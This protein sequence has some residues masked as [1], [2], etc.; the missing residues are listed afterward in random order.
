MEEGPRITK[1]QELQLVECRVLIRWVGGRICPPPRSVWQ[2]RYMCQQCRYSRWTSTFLWKRHLAQSRRH[3]SYRLNRW[4]RQSGILPYP[5]TFY[6]SS[7]KFQ[8][9]IWH[10]NVISSVGRAPC[11]HQKSLYHILYV[12]PGLCTMGPGITWAYFSFD[13]LILRLWG[14]LRLHTINFSTDNCKCNA[15]T[16]YWEGNVLLSKAIYVLQCLNKILK[17]CCYK[18]NS[19]GRRHCTH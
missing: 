15:I 1:W 11:L 12:S 10:I 6:D 7:N 3:W 8:L 18:L 19:W 4:H 9:I 16:I 17:F 14:A 2:A 13:F 5:H